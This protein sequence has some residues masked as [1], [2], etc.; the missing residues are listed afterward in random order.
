MRLLLNAP[1]GQSATREPQAADGR[2]AHTAGAA[3][4]GVFTSD[5]SVSDFQAG[6]AV[7]AGSA[8]AA[9]SGP[10]VR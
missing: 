7:T 6:Q 1:A 4:N 10:G 2:L 5:P 3:P 9:R 8:S